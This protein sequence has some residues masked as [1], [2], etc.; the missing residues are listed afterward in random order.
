MEV[1]CAGHSPVGGTFNTSRLMFGE[2]R[3]ENKGWG[4]E[5]KVTG[6]GWNDTLNLILLPIKH[7]I[8]VIELVIRI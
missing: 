8:T 3:S 2:V 5:Q 1:S 4:A 7:I 6:E